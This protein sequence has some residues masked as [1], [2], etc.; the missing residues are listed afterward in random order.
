MYRPFLIAGMLAAISNSPASAQ[1]LSTED[2]A[3]RMEQI[4]AMCRQMTLNRSGSGYDLQGNIEGDGS[5]LLDQLADLGAGISGRTYSW[6]M[7]GIS[8]PEQD[9]PAFARWCTETMI[10][11]LIPNQ[12][13]ALDNDFG[14]VKVGT[15]QSFTACD[16][17]S[18]LRVTVM[19]DTARRPLQQI[20]LSGVDLDG[21]RTRLEAGPPVV[22]RIGCE[23]ALVRTDRDTG[24]YAVMSRRLAAE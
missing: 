18:H 21:G 12:Q 22:T 10:D 3:A 15:G 23:V 13:S 6:T 1:R 14:E 9:D 7:E 8:P 4:T 19:A 2:L 24:F 11:R 5:W 16:P 17:D 20:V